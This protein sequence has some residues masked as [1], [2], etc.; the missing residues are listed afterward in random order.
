MGIKPQ[1]WKY[2]AKALGA[3]MG[4]API[5]ISKKRGWTLCYDSMDRR[6]PKTKTAVTASRSRG[7]HMEPRPQRCVWAMLFLLLLLFLLVLLI[8]RL[9][10]PKKHLPAQ[11]K[12]LRFLHLGNHGSRH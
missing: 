3:A 6:T 4:Q 9:Q 5:S 11:K 7:R 2:Q 8:K 12:H 10:L 1:I